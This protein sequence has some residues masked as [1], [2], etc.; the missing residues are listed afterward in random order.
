MLQGMGESMSLYFKFTVYGLV[1]I[2]R[3]IKYV[4]CSDKKG[5]AAFFNVYIGVLNF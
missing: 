5:S 3:D 1:T 2:G 4:L